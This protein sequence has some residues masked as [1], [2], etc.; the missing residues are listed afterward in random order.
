MEGKR[1]PGPWRVARGR[2]VYSVE[3]GEG[4]AVA[5]M[6]SDPAIQEANARLIAAAPDMLEALREVADLE[7]GHFATA[8]A[9]K[10]I[11]RAAIARATGGAS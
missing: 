11:A 10:G 7:P 3:D 6:W 9:A 2:A 1:T 5:Q 8:S 4:F